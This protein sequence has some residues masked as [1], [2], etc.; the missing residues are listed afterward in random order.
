MDLRAR[1]QDG[2]FLFIG[3]G[4]IICNG[5][6]IKKN[7]ASDRGGGIYALSPSSV[8]ISCDLLS[9][10]SPSGAAVYVT[11][12]ESVELYDMSV[13]NNEFSC[14]S[15]AVFV[16][17][18]SVI[19]TDVTF[20]AGNANEGESSKHAVQLD[21]SSSFKATSCTFN[22]WNGET[23]I[24]SNNIEN[25]SLVLD[26]CDFSESSPSITVVSSESFAKI[27]NTRFAALTF[28]S[29]ADPS[30]LVS[31]ALTCNGGD[32]GTDV[33]GEGICVDTSLGVLCECLPSGAC[34]QDDAVLWLQ[35]ISCDEAEDEKMYTAGEN[36]SFELVVAADEEHTSD[37][38]WAI[39]YGENN[40]AF[41][42][43]PSAGILSPGSNVTVKVEG[44]PVNFEAGGSRDFKTNFT[45][46]IES[47]GLI[48]EADEIGVKP[49]FYYCGSSKYALEGEDAYSCESCFELEG[50][51]DGVSCTTAGATLASIYIIEGYWRE[52]EDSSYI[53]EC[54]ISDACQGLDG[55]VT[56]SDDYCAT[57]YTG[58]CKADIL[59]PTTN[60]ISR[61]LRRNVESLLAPLH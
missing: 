30:V 13:S 44:S 50:E 42:I 57:G 3:S 43:I 10:A 7:E 54:P 21:S 20:A 6:T 61:L 25:G 58:P 33:C 56:T 15:S 14:G 37:A 9:N 46:N 22:D 59:T 4:S 60:R 39:T 5:A 34:L 17:S 48:G 53:H 8:N 35:C 23:I 28:E 1:S 36:V 31:K 11:N 16:V 24:D 12:A 55:A 27:R 2:G 26:N 49:V 45:L 51:T 32:D 18:S 19:A 52:S 38:I 29:A 40:L 41:D 47:G